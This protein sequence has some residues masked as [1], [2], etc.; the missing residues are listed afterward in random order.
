VASRQSAGRLPGDYENL[1]SAG[2]ERYER[3][4]RMKTWHW[5][6]LLLIVA[7]V[8]FFLGRYLSTLKTAYS[9]RDKIGAAL[10]IASGAS[11]LF[12]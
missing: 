9:N 3:L 5:L 11:T 2:A 4:A 6:L 1:Q 12:S 7:L 10:D 8:A